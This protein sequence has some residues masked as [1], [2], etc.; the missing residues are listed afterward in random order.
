MQK[1]DSCPQSRFGR[2][3]LTGGVALVA[4]LPWCNSSAKGRSAKPNPCCPRPTPRG[5]LRRHPIPNCLTQRDSLRHSGLPLRRSCP[6]W[7]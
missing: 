1:P 6:Q 2:L 5:S 4:M 7:L 3:V